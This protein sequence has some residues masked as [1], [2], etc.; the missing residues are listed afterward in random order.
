MSKP[1]VLDL[2]EDDDPDPDPFAFLRIMAMIFWRGRRL[3]RA[4]TGLGLDLNDDMA[5]VCF[6]LP[7]QV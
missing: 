6:Y 7:L 1:L 4:Q 5:T 2:L 3:D